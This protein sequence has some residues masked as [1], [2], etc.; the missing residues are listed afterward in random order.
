MARLLAN[1][2]GLDTLLGDLLL[3]DAAVCSTWEI[4]PLAKAFAKALAEYV[5]PAPRKFSSSCTKTTSCSHVLWNFLPFLPL[6]L[7]V[8]FHRSWLP[9]ISLA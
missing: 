3:Y 6:S 9:K 8:A 4:E 5:W 7:L 2:L 1:V